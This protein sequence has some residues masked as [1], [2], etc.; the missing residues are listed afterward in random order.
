MMAK[1]LDINGAFKV[2]IVGRRIEKLEDIASTAVNPF[3]RSMPFPDTSSAR[4]ARLSNDQFVS[5]R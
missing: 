5:S 3:L 4:F 2:Y 1:A